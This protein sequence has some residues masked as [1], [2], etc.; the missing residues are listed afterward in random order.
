MRSK[1]D[2]NRERAMSAARALG[3]LPDW[4]E[5]D[6]RS[7][8]VDLLTNL[9]HLCNSEGIDFEAALA[10]SAIHFEEEK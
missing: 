9:R 10:M 2:M 3:Q 8:V 7:N 6:N 1:K 4:W 5:N